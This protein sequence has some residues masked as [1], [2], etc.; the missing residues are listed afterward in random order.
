MTDKKDTSEVPEQAPEQATQQ[1]YDAD[2][3][4]N[5]N[6]KIVDEVTGEEKVWGYSGTDWSGHYYIVNGILR[7][8]KGEIGS[9]L[10]IGAG[11]GS[12]VDYANRAG[13]RCIGYDFSE[14]AVNNPLNYA[15]GN[16]FVGN[17]TNIAEE[18]DSYDVVYSSDMLEHIYKSKVP[19]VIRE[20]YRVTKR[21]V[22]LQ[23]PCPG[24]GDVEGEFDEEIHDKMHPHYAHYMHAGHLNM[25]CRMW[26]DQ[27]FKDCGFKIRDDL[28]TIFR[29]NTPNPILTNWFNIVILEKGE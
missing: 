25:S 3:F 17:A 24:V 20:F 6:K 22:F 23:F 27:L 28:V 18:N 8:F 7:T 5:A 9:V 13:L 16:L 15:T 21:W 26:W 2:Y 12:F 14:W 4:V 11:Q 29:D 1:Y 10:D 19:A